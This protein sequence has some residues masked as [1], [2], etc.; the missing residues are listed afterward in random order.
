MAIWGYLMLNFREMILALREYTTK[1][2]WLNVLWWLLLVISLTG[3]STGFGKTISTTKP[4]HELR[5]SHVVNKHR[6]ANSKKLR[7]KRDFPQLQIVSVEES[8]DTIIYAFILGCVYFAICCSN[9]FHDHPIAIESPV[10]MGNAAYPVWC[11]FLLGGSS[12]LVSR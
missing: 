3:I 4:Q 11:H 7:L 1:Y 9:F 6:K 5:I 10:G 8:S 2:T 12:Q